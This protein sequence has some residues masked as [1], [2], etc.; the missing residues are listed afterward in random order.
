MRWSVTIGSFKG[1]AVRIHVTFLLFLVW[2]GASAYSRGGLDAARDS[3]LFILAI[4]TCVVLHEFGHILTA[5]RFGIVSK[6]VTLLPI[7]GVADMEKMPDKPW[8]E[9]LV[10]LAG[11]AVNV[12]IA[13]VIVLGLGVADLEG[14][15]RIDD[16]QLG[17]LQRLAAANLFIAVFNLVPAFPM[18]GGR[19]LRATLAMWLGQEKATAIAAT[20]GQGFAF[21][22]GFAGLFGNPLLLFIAIF[23]YMAAA[24]EA[25]M[26]FASAATRD[27][28]AEDVMETRFMTLDRA[29]T[30]QEAVDAMLATSQEEFP[31][32]D[33]Q[34]RLTGLLRRSDIIDALK[35]TPP[36]AP[37]AQFVQKDTPVI[38]ARSTLDKALKQLEAASA[39]GVVDDDGRL[40]GLI[41]RQSIAEVMMIRSVRPDW[42]FARH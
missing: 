16:P 3:L 15:L 21:L 22:L 4:F 2:I 8:Q 37:I 27:V 9:L 35:E 39:L 11:P 38:A 42:R 40:E 19:V 36:A 17:L 30:V 20:I 28:A 1:T 24:G 6:V 25:Q 32:L 5:R 10:A 29:A 12:A 23:V 41:T 33:P 18:D 14:A 7:G 13:G 31:V 34:G 26:T